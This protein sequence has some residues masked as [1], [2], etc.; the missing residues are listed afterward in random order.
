MLAENTLLVRYTVIG[1]DAVYAIP[2]RVYRPEDVAVT[3]SSDGRTETELALGKDYSVQLVATG[4]AELRLAAGVVGGAVPAGA[5]LAIASAIP[6]TQEADFSNTATVNTGALETQLDREV[7]MIQQLHTELKRAVKVPAASSESPEDLLQNIYESEDNAAQSAAEAAESA[8]AAAESEVAAAGSAGVAAEQREA[9][10][11]CAREAQAAR[12]AAISQT[13]AANTL[14]ETELGKINAIV[15][16]NRTDQQ[17]AVDKAKQ[18]AGKAPDQPVDYDADGNPEYSAKH[19]AMKYKWGLALDTPF[20]VDDPEAQAAL[21]AQMPPGAFV[22]APVDEEEDESGNGD[23]YVSNNYLQ[24]YNSE[25]WITESGTFTAPV[26]GD[27]DILLIGGGEGGFAILNSDGSRYAH[28]GASGDYKSILIHLTKGQ[29]IPVTIGSGGIGITSNSLSRNGSITIFGDISTI[30]PESSGFRGFMGSRQYSQTVIGIVTTPGGFGA[31]YLNIGF[32]GSGGM[33]VVENAAL[34][35]NGAQGAIRLRYHDP[36]KANGPVAAAST[37]ALS[38]KAARAAKSATVTTVNLYD[39]ETGQGSVWREED[40]PAQL[41][42]GLI[43]QEAWQAICEQKAAEAH[44]AWLA[45]PDTEAERFR[46]LRSARDARLAA[47]DYL[48][49]P[50]YP[51]TSEQKVAVT[52]Y[53]QA[54][55][56]LPAKDGAP[57]DGGGEL[58]PWPEMP[59][60]GAEEEA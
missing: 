2:F 21:A 44:A 1:G 51:L 37:L 60:L 57:W 24:P 23:V 9:A 15:A 30:M 36:A 49:A 28:S 14:M 33:A 40:A 5:T 18:W 26:T 22:T 10:C 38:R 46:L 59:T 47:T 8:A 31:R 4:G 58:T 56:D 29:S 3:W 32:Y 45:D 16:A 52:I 41:A 27:F 50:D 54:L 25:E 20:P 12:D 35:C 43:T 42:R 17:A 53:R 11:V 7:Q 6:E 19:Y 48:A 39:P 13:E 34:V 55:R